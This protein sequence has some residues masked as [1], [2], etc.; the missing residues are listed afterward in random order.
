MD[1]P[2]DP[3]RFYAIVWNIV[4]QIPA[5]SASTYG[6]IASMMLPPA[7]VDPSDFERIAPRW[8]GKAMNAVSSKDDPLIP[9]QRVVNGQG[10]ISLPEGSSAALEQ[11]A[12]LEREGIPFDKNNRIDLKT[13]GWEGPDETWLRDHNLFTP[14]PLKKPSTDNPQQLTLF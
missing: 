5:G 11:R 8:V 9:W 6:Q 2:P 12:R 14:R 1:F 4:K 13:V 7:G 10:G 3:E